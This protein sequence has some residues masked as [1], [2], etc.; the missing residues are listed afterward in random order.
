MSAVISHILP[1]SSARYD[2]GALAPYLIKWFKDGLSIKIN[3]LPILFGSCFYNYSW[4]RQRSA[5]C[6][7]INVVLVSTG[8]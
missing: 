5:Y 1:I 3:P 2:R 6:S 4:S 8:D 7:S